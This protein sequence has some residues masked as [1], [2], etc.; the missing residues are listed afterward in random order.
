MNLFMVCPRLDPRQLT[1]LPK[2]YSFRTI[3]PHELPL[4]E[5]F[6]FDDPQEAEEHRGYMRAFY[7]DVY[8]PR[9]ELFF[10]RCTFV[11]DAQDTP[12]GT[13]FLWE[14]FDPPFTTLHWLKVKQ[15]HEGLGIGRALISHLMR[16]LPETRYPVYLHTQPESARA[17]RLYTGFGFQLITDPQVGHRTNDLEEGLRMLRAIMPETAMR[18]LRFTPAPV[19]FLLAAQRHPGNPF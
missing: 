7:R 16:E 1:A 15:S 18:R 17:I 19:T 11:C 3:R 4:W 12:V 9:E 5:A 6:H 8:A 2:G 13:A 10:R 14:V